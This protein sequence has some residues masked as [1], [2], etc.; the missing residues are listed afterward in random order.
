MFIYMQKN[1]HATN[2][3]DIADQRILQSHWL[4]TIPDHATQKK[5]SLFLPFSNV[6]LSAKIIK[7][8]NRL[9]KKALLIKK[10]CNLIA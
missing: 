9:I 4:K 10:S 3:A 6:S 1:H 2:S 5:G 8:I 7:M